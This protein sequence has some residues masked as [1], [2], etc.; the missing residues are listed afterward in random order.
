MAD[1]DEFNVEDQLNYE[2]EVG[3][4][5]GDESTDMEDPELEAIKV[6]YCCN[7]TLRNFL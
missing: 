3:E 1:T 2:A 5:E 4:G 6:L 7:S